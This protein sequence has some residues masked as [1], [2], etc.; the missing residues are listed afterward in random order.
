MDKEVAGQPLW[1][2]AVGAVV[3]VGGF[4]YFRSHQSSSATSGQGA[5]QSGGGGGG[6]FTSRSSFQETITELHSHPSKHHK[7][8]G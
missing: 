8:G 2:W 5:G 3:I 6:K 4:L 7:K 1:L